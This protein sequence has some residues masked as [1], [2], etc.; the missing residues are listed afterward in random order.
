MSK[1]DVHRR[2]IAEIMAFLAAGG[3]AGIV[4]RPQDIA[5]GTA[6]EVDLSG[7]EFVDLM[8]WLEHERV[9]RIVGKPDM[10]ISLIVSSRFRRW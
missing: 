5:G 7:E 4:M 9:V 10:R 3:L 6:G 8:R 1:L 2:A